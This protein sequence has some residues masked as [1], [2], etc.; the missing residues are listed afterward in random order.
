MNWVTCDCALG[1]AFANCNDSCDFYLAGF[2]T[3]RLHTYKPS[4]FLSAAVEFVG[5]VIL[6]C[7]ICD[8]RQGFHRQPVHQKVT[9]GDDDCKLDDTKV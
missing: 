4:F 6:L 8:H 9:L 3:D 1:F 2:M 7:V 5:A